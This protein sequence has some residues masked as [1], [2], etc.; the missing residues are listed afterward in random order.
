MIIRNVRHKGLR[1][2]IEQDSTAGLP[3]AVVSKVRDILAFLQAMAAEDELQAATAW[4]AHLLKGERAGV[5]A[6]H[7][8]RNWRIT[9]RVDRQEIEIVDLNY[10]DYH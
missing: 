8:T 5:W 7:V 10:E 3:A 4:K 2:L 1:A 9:F 6:L